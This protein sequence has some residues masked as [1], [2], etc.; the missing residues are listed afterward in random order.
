M[1]FK[2]LNNLYK[3]K[4]RLYESLRMAKNSGADPEVI[5]IRINDLEYDIA[6]VKKEIDFEESM[7]PFV[8]MLCVF[9]ICCAIILVSAIINY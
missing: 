7:K 1:L 4:T 8:Y 3:L 6:K 9:V 5:S 2:K